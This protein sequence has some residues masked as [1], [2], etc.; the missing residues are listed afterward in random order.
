M[1]TCPNCESSLLNFVKICTKCGSTLPNTQNTQSFD[2]IIPLNVHSKNINQALNHSSL[3]E[4]FS[5]IP[6]IP[7]LPDLIQEMQEL[8]D[9]TVDEMDRYG[10]TYDGSKFRYK[11]MVFDNLNDA[12]VIPPFLT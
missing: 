7:E 6:P 1:Q 8:R 2:E 4:S 10:I 5:D 11:T 12:M 9:L 3:K